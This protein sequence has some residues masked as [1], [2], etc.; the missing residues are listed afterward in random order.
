VPF[1]S[2][3]IS[4][5]HTNHEFSQPNT[6]ALANNCTRGC[7]IEIKPGPRT[8]LRRTNDWLFIEIGGGRVPLTEEQLTAWQVDGG[9]IAP[10]ANPE[11]EEPLMSRVLTSR[12]HRAS[13][14]HIVERGLSASRRT[15][16]LRG[17]ISGHAIWSHRHALLWGR[18]DCA[19]RE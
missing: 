11:V 19:G 8:K 9:A 10:Q 6:N 5:T 16:S 15:H 17:S 12:F 1:W 2:L 18:G 4:F 14:P 7:F 3:M 13:R